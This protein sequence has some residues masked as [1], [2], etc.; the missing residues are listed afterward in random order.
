V[1]FSSA[2]HFPWKVNTNENKKQFNINNET[3]LKDW[4]CMCLVSF[5]VLLSAPCVQGGWSTLFYTAFARCLRVTCAQDS[6]QEPLIITTT[7]RPL[8]KH[9][10]THCQNVYNF[11]ELQNEPVFWFSW[12]MQRSASLKHRGRGCIP[13]YRRRSR[14]DTLNT[15]QVRNI[16]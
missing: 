11:P 12:V 1:H 8:S 14:Q 3:L 9:T 4:R 16:R 5:S 7:L 10:D 15:E 13:L 2:V 6:I